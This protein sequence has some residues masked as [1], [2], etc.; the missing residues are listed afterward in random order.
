M[1]KKFLCLLFFLCLASCAA[2]VS[3][4]PLALDFSSPRKKDLLRQRVEAFW[5]YMIQGDLERAYSFYDPFFRA[6]MDVKEF[7]VKHQT[8][9]YKK[10]E[11]IDAKIEGN[12]AKVKVKVTYYIPKIKVINRTFSVPETTK[13]FEETWLFIGD[14]WYRQY[15][16]GLTGKGVVYY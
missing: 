9:K 4:R 2:N 8:V 6:K 1:I 13:E 16:F 5:R 11:F 3:E 14:N 10:A 15:I 7:V 12:I